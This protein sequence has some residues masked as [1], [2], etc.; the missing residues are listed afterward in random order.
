MRSS[1]SEAA[2]NYY[3][4]LPFWWSLMKCYYTHLLLPRPTRKFALS[5][6]G[7]VPDFRYAAQGVYNTSIDPFNNIMYTRTRIHAGGRVCVCITYYAVLTFKRI[8]RKPFQSEFLRIS[9]LTERNRP[10]DFSGSVE[11]IRQKR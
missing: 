4:V 11:S 10:D 6:N 2:A 3:C 1:F 9:V 5:D 8:V 7:P